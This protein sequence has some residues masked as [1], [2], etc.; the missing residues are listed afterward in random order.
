MNVKLVCVSVSVYVIWKIQVKS[1]LH[2]NQFAT[3]YIYYTNIHTY[4]NVLLSQYHVINM[5]MNIEHVVRGNNE[6]SFRLTSKWEAIHVL[7]YK[8]RAAKTI[9]SNNSHRRS[10]FAFSWNYY[11]NHIQFDIYFIVRIGF[12]ACVCF[13]C[14]LI[15][16]LSLCHY[17]NS[18]LTSIWW[19]VN[20]LHHPKRIAFPCAAIKL[21]F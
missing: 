11:R 18:I 19:S 2:L 4:H 1:I 14:A 9:E 7:S 13:A 17:Y 21:F 12:F 3:L 10:N 16:L 6:Q 5:S 20:D 8:K 15:I